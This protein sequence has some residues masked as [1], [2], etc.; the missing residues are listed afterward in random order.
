MVEGAWGLVDWENYSILI[1]CL[2]QANNYPYC[3]IQKIS[4]PPPQ[5]WF[6]PRPH[7]LHPCG[8]FQFLLPY[9][10]TPPNP[11]RKFQSLLWVECG[12]FLEQPSP[13]HLTAFGRNWISPRIYCGSG[14]EKN[15]G[16]GE[17]MKNSLCVQIY[18]NN[19]SIVIKLALVEKVYVYL[20]RHC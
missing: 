10:P 6:F 20:F 19:Q 12:Y 9:R 17:V 16:K 2:G 18:I 11:T 4:I 15:N 13:S 1:G 7:P 3:V 8:Y 5:N 14:K